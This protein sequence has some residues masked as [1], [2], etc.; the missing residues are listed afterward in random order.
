MIVEYD[1]RKRDL[2]I[3]VLSTICKYYNTNNE[4]LSLEQV[5]EVLDETKDYLH[6]LQFLRLPIEIVKARN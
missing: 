3:A 5:Y 2:Y 1:D 6:N 4:P